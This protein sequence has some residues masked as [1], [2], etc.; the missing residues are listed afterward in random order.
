MLTDCPTLALPYNIRSVLYNIRGIREIVNCTLSAV[1]NY[2]RNIIVIIRLIR[3]S[4]AHLAEIHPE[5]APLHSS[6]IYFS[7]RAQLIQSNKGVC[8]NHPVVQGLPTPILECVTSGFGP[9]ARPALFNALQRISD[10]ITGTLKTAHVG[11]REIWPKSSIEVNEITRMEYWKEL[12]EKCSGRMNRESLL[13]NRRR[14]SFWGCRSGVRTLRPRCTFRHICYGRQKRHS[15][16]KALAQCWIRNSME[17]A[18]N[19]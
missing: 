10:V 4:K 19:I 12:V 8:F 17:I 6:C 9:H 13:T 16:Q 2:E 5:T 7:R 11:R 3:N 18:E 15:H 14:I 1:K